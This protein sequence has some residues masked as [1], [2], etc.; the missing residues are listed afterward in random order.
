MLDIASRL[1]WNAFRFVV[2]VAETGSLSGAARQLKVSQPTVGRK[3]SELEQQLK[4]QLFDKL[5]NGY[6]LT[7]AGRTILELCLDMQSN[8]LGIERLVAGQDQ[9]LSG[10]IRVSTTEGL[11]TYWLMP[12][13]H[14][15]R[16]DHPSI[17]IDMLISTSMLDLIRREADVALRLGNPGSDDLVGRKL[18]HIAFGLYGS[19]SYF[20][21]HGIPSDLADLARHTIIE[22]SGSL[23]NVDQATKLREL[24]GDSTIAL[25]CNHL[26]AQIAATAAGLGLFAMPCY[27]GDKTN[28]FQRVLKDDFNVTIDLWLLTH[29]DLR[30]IARIRAMLDFLAAKVQEDEVALAGSASQ[31]RGGVNLSDEDRES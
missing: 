20:Q 3:I 28:D 1:D 6:S 30:S 7:P 2:A 16:A 10:Q 25:H 18:G 21:R 5:F 9:D 29:R 8:A 27:V 15:W 22:S 4:V 17:K 31:S 26:P 13:L 12:K 23:M 11:G 19:L 14:E 24:T